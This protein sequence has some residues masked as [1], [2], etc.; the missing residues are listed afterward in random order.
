MGTSSYGLRLHFHWQIFRLFNAVR[1]PYLLTAIVCSALCVIYSVSGHKHIS[2]TDFAAI[3]LATVLLV[4]VL[5]IDYTHRD[6]QKFQ[7][8]YFERWSKIKEKEDTGSAKEV[9]EEAIK[10]MQEKHHKKYH[11]WYK[12]PKN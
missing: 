10:S 11:K 3:I 2:G 1:T 7:K 6:M 8:D 9:Y 12:F 4:I 5:L